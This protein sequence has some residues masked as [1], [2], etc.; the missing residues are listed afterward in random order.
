MRKI[1]IGDIHGCDKALEVLLEAIDPR[2]DDTIITLGDCVD[3]GGNTKGVIDRLIDL[4]EKCTL[5]PLLGNHELMLMRAFGGNDDL[6]YWL[7]FGGVQALTS[8]GCV[9]HIDHH[10]LK[11]IIPR[12]HMSFITGCIEFYEDDDNIFVHAN[13]DPKIPMQEQRE[14][15]SFWTNLDT[16]TPDPHRSGK[17]VWVGHSPQI[18][19]DVLDLG[20]LVCLDTN[21]CQTGWIT[22]VDVN[23][24]QI[25]QANEYKELRERDGFQTT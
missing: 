20:Y 14:E 18:S 23:T 1:A 10:R 6:G 22:A 21:G 17:T 5:I 4:K 25:W 12:D 24:R 9:G 16:C 13:Y 7:K 2:P 8:Y 3:R 19:G 11:N 15:I